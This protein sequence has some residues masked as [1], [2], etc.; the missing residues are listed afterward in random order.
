MNET[1]KNL[2]ER[3]CVR[4]YKN[5]Q[6]KEEELEQIL[7]AGMYA[8]CGMGAQS[9]VMVV[10]QNKDLIRKISQMNALVMGKTGVDPFFGAPTLV[11]V[12]A[13]SS[14]MTYV[15]DGALVM[16]NLMN[17]AHAIGVDSC[18]VHRARQVF[19]TE[20]GR[21]LMMGWGLDSNYVGIGDCLLGYRDG[22][23]PE[24]KPRKD[25]FV[26]RVH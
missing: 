22:E 26:I 13:D 24:A 5:E 16:G 2:R 25:N 11:I 7:E 12:F 9:P 8:P 10:I 14:R 20:E 1:L 6:I 15:E 3:R 4:S 18:W 17:A 21:A 23:Y 19:E